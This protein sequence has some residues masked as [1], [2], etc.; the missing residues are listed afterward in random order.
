MAKKL[1]PIPR[2][3]SRTITVRLLLLKIK[4]LILDEPERL[5]MDMWLQRF[6]GNL[7]SMGDSATASPAC[8][9][10]A[11][12]AGWGAV[13]LRPDRVS[14]ETIGNNTSRVIGDLIGYKSWPKPAGR[15]FS[16]V[17]SSEFGETVPFL[18]TPGTR[19]HAEFVAKRID[20]YMAQHPDIL[21][22]KIDVAAARRA[23]AGKP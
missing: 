21:N 6:N 5:N 12:M 11:C 3:T 8:G 16:A 14:A 20:T 1:A 13:L 19:A 17:A 22:R 18:P 2:V 9:T 15:L 10:V 7:T 23:L 4:R